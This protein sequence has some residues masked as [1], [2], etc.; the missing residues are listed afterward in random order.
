MDTESKQNTFKKSKILL[1]FL[2]RKKNSTEPWKYAVL[3]S[4]AW[5]TYFCLPN[6]KTELAQWFQDSEVSQAP[7]PLYTSLHMG[8]NNVCHWATHSFTVVH[9]RAFSSSLNTS[10]Y[11]VTTFST[12]S[13][14]ICLI[15]PQF[16]WTLLSQS[17]YS[18][19]CPAFFTISNWALAA[20][21]PSSVHFAPLKKYSLKE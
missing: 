21:L 12:H 10:G 11:F 20:G 14:F 15:S 2:R 7:F 13:N 6:E 18:K 4:V 19:L 1:N 3:G 8:R 16:N 17:C 5:C 9:C